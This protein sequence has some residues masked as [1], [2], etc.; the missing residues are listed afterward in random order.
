V[1]WEGGQIKPGEYDDFEV[2]TG[3]MPSDPTTLLFP[4][5]QSYDNGEDVAWIDRPTPGGPEPAN[6]APALQVVAAGAQPGAPADA[7]PTTVGSSASTTATAAPVIVAAGPTGAASGSDLAS[8]V[9][10]TRTISIVALV[11]GVLALLAAVVVAVVVLGSRRRP[12]AT[13]PP[14]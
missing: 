4:T 12:T 1:D 8:R 9:D 13:R 6:P 14:T 7:P 5:I 11:V 2:N 3:P 10:S